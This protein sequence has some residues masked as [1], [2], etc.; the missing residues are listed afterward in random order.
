[1]QRKA[2]RATVG[3]VDVDIPIG[4]LVA[5]QSLRYNATG[6]PGATPI[7]DSAA[8]GAGDVVGPAGAT[9]NHIALF[10]GVTGKLLKDT[11]PI[12]VAAGVMTAVTSVNGVVVEAHAARHLPG[13]ADSMFPGTW[14]AGDVAQ[15]SGAAWVQKFFKT[16]TLAAQHAVNTTTL[17]TIAGLSYALPRAG[18]YR[19]ELVIF[20][21]QSAN[22]ATG[23]AINLS[24]NFTSCSF[25]IQHPRAAAVVAFGTRVTAQNTANVDTRTTAALTLPVTITGIVVTSGAA[26]LN[27]Q[28]QRATVNTVTIEIGSGGAVV[29]L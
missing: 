4:T 6:G 10:N 22:T 1:M 19:F 9:D 25:M 20:V 14:A 13:A 12:V 27:F 11:S 18:T 3:G 15:W 21:T 8:G 17:V 16:L 5:G 28:A 23:Y 24:T 2:I 26:T 7:I 29:E